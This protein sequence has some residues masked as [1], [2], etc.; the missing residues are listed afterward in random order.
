MLFGL[1]VGQEPVGK[2][3][4]RVGD[5][6]P[7]RD[8]LKNGMGESI[9]DPGP[10]GDLVINQGTYRTEYIYPSDTMRRATSAPSSPTMARRTA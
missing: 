4:I 5:N 10:Y 8:D 7:L 9:T 6:V 2:V 1:V 3:Y